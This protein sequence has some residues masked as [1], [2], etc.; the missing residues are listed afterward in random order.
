MGKVFKVRNLIS[1][2]I[3]AMKVLLPETDAT[4][5]LAERFSR[6]IKLVASLEHPNIA[7]LRTAVR[8]GN[9]MLMIMSTLNLHA[10]H[11]VPS[12]ATPF[13]P[14]GIARDCV[15]IMGLITTM[16]DS[17]HGNRPRRSVKIG[18]SADNVGG[19]Y[20]HENNPCRR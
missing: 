7:S 10:G 13:L 12:G 19:G 11:T 4:P 16:R 18:R 15:L 3:E 20:S 14:C 1:D 2:R 5:E 9:Q 6:E 8:A 17:R